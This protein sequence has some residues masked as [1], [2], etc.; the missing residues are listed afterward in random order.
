MK[1]RF[2]GNSGVRV[3]EIGLG[4]MAYGGAQYQFTDQPVS[5]EDAVKTLIK[6]LELEINHIDCADIYGAYG[7]AEK[8]VGETVKGYNREEIILSSKVMMPMSRNELDRGLSRKHLMKSIDRTLGNLDTGY[9]DL[10]Y[11]HRFDHYTPLKE[12]IKSMNILIDQSKIRYWGTSNWSAAELERTFAICERYGWEGPI[13][14]QTKYNLFNRYCGEFGLQYVMDEHGLG[15]V[16][17]KILAEGVFAGVYGGKTYAD[18]NEDEKKEIQNKIGDTVFDETVFVNLLRFDEIA[19]ELDINPS[20][21]SYAWIL[22]V[23]N[24]SVA[25]MSTRKPERIADNI[26]ALDVTLS[27]ETVN[28]INGLFKPEFNGWTTYNIIKSRGGPRVLGKISEDMM[29]F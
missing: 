11:A 23:D 14:D 29:K 21:L 28:E 3:S 13:V 27:T 9:V 19:K 5:K 18:L 1:Y 16:P 17:Y 10:Y 2:L 25:L 12:V 6:A 7:N 22:Q 8:I 24:V 26:A 4:T 15:L 20:Q